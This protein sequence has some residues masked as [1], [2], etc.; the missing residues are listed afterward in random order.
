MYLH[1]FENLIFYLSKQIAHNFDETLEDED[2]SFQH[3]SQM[4]LPQ[5]LK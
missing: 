5:F 1:L 4:H 3:F 2:L